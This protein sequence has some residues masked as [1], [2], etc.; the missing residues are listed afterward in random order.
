[1]KIVGREKDL[2][3]SGGLNV[4]PIE[5]ETVINRYQGVVESAVIGVPH[6]DFG[7]AVIAVIVYSDQGQLRPNH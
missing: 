6:A 3:I 7:E 5:V 1:M 2:I 4:Y